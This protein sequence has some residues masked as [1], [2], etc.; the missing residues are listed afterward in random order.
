M[1][2]IRYSL[3]QLAV[4]CYLIIKNKKAIL[5]DPGDEASFLLEE[6]RKRDLNLLAIL[7]T[8]GHFDH[9]MAV[10]EIQESLRVNL[11]LNKKDYFLIKNLVRSAQYFLGYQ[12]VTIPIKKVIDICHSQ[13]LTFEEFKVKV[14]PTPGHTPGSVAFYFEKEKIVF[15][16]DTLF[17]RGIGRYDFSYSNKN[18]LKESIKKII[19]L[20]SET[21]ICPGHGEETTV[22]KQKAIIDQFISLEV[23]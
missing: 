5:I 20:P 14:I 15:S 11:Y 18:H 23:S 17:K 2:I 22:A 6:I 3:G 9:L 12:I 19:S 13:F 10:G 1:R 8:H 4:N 21:V 7:A 16:G